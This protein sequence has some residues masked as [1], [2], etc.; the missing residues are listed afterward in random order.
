MKMQDIELTATLSTAKEWAEKMKAGG[1]DISSCYQ[2]GKCSA[3]CPMAS[4][5]D[6]SPRQVVRLLQLGVADEAL[7]SRSIWLCA[8]CETCATRCPRDVDVA[9]M[10][11]ILRIESDRAGVAALPHIPIFHKTFLESVENHARV[12]ETELMMKFNM[13][14]GKLFNN[15]DLGPKMMQKGKLHV[16][17]PKVEGGQAVKKIF[18]RVREM[19]VD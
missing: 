8:S 14:S 6:Y 17:A 2:C 3:G 4:A 16:F 1:V 9:K 10:M 12:A 13:R 15:V 5:M 18:A 11:D 19:G 7:R